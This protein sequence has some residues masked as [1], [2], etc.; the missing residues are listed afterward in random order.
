MAGMGGSPGPRGKQKHLNLLKSVLLEPFQIF[1]K[2]EAKITH[3]LATGRNFAG[4]AN[5]LSGVEGT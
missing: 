4:D 1:H 3:H 5:A 2:A